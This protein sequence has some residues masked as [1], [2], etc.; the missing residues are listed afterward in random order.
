MPFSI[1]I[2]KRGHLSITTLGMLTLSITI[3][4]RDIQY[5]NTQH[6]I[7]KHNNFKKGHLSIQHSAY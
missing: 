7:D 1:T 4:K 5:K 3:L 2:L 6:I